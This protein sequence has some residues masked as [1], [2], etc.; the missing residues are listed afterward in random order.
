MA[1]KAARECKVEIV[2]IHKGYES[3]WESSQVFKLFL[4]KVIY[5]I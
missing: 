1:F 5:S 4:G 3:K 2:P